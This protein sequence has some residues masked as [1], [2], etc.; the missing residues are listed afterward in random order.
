M[1]AVICIKK[2][3]SVDDLVAKWDDGSFIIVLLQKSIDEGITTAENIK[4]DLTELLTITSSV[5]ATL[6]FGVH[7]IDTLFSIDENIRFT[8]ERLEDARRLGGNKII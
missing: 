7:M 5:A 8:T 1:S 4:A 3:T 2:N 6:S